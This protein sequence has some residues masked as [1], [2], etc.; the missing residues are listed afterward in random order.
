MILDQKRKNQPVINISPHQVETEG[1]NCKRETK[2]KSLL[3]AGQEFAQGKHLV[4]NNHVIEIIV[5]VVFIQTSE[6]VFMG[7]CPLVSGKHF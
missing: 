5:I 7:T 6:R 2:S 1:S 4:I 3:E